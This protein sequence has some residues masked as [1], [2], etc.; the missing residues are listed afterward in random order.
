[1]DL[2]IVET[3]ATPMP[4][5]WYATTLDPAGRSPAAGAFL[6]FLTTPAATQVMRAPEDG[7][8]RARF[9]PPIHVSIWS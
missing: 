5:Y 1:G 2:T 9:R 7:V 8:P 6:D 4:A 3:A